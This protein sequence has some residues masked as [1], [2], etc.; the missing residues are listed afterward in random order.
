MELQL[1]NDVLRVH[2]VKNGDSFSVHFSNG[3][4]KDNCDVLINSTTKDESALAKK[5]YLDNNNTKD[6]NLKDYDEI[7]VDLVNKKVY[8]D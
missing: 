2:Y 6:Y 5:T 8:A 1:K 4:P 7:T 3:K